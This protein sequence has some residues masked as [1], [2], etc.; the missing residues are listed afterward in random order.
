VCPA[1]PVIIDGPTKLAT[2]HQHRRKRVGWPNRHGDA[3]L[4]FAR[5]YHDA[6]IKIL[7]SPTSQVV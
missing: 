2:A 7:G 6:D 4:I 5:E 3:M 1:M